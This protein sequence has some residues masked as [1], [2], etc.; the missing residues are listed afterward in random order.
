MNVIYYKD[1]IIVHLAVPAPFR[2]GYQPFN[3]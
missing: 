3:F 1:L 2:L